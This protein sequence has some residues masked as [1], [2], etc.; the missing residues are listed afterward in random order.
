MSNPRRPSFVLGMWFVVLLPIDLTHAEQAGAAAKE[1]ALATPSFLG[2]KAAEAV[3]AAGTQGLSLELE[4]GDSA[5]TSDLE[6]SVYAQSPDSGAPRPSGPVLVKLYSKPTTIHASPVQA[7]R[8]VKQGARIP[9]FIGLA[10]DEANTV[11]VNLGL[12]LSS[13]VGLPADSY[14]KRSQIYAQMPAA[15]S[16]SD[17]GRVEVV[18][19]NPAG[20]LAVDPEQS[21]DLRA[22]GLASVQDRA[23]SGVDPE[24]GRL[25]LR[26]VDVL[27]LAGASALT[28][29]RRF[30]PE[31]RKPGLLGNRWRIHWEKSLS[32]SG[33]LAAIDDGGLLHFFHFDAARNVWTSVMGER[34]T[35]DRDRSVLQKG[36]GSEL[37]FDSAGRCTEVVEPDGTRFKISYDDNGRL[38]H[39]TGPF[40]T[41]IRFLVTAN[42]RLARV[43]CSNGMSVRYGFGTTPGWNVPRDL[44]FRFEYDRRG[45]PVRIEDP[46]RG[47][48]DIEY[49]EKQR[50]LRRSWLDSGDE[51]YS[52]DDAGGIRRFTDS[53]GRTSVVQIVRSRDRQTITTTDPW[54][55]QEYR[56]FDSNHRLIKKRD[57]TGL[58]SVYQYDASGRT[59]QI[60][61][62]D[63]TTALEYLKNTLLPTRIDSPAGTTA[64]EYDARLQLTRVLAGREVLRER[65][66]DAS[67][68]LASSKEGDGPETKY[69]HD[70]E[71]RLTAT[72]SASSGRTAF[73]YDRRGNLVECVDALGNKATWSY[74]PY[75]RLVAS[76]DPLGRE[77]K[78]TYG[79]RGELT[80]IV[81]AKGQRQFT[82]RRDGKL[83]CQKGPGDRMMDYVYDPRGRLIQRRSSAG[84][85]E[86][87]SYDPDGQLIESRSSTGAVWKYQY[88]HGGRLIE[89]V[90]PIGYRK[91]LTYDKRGYLST[92]TDGLGR[93][94][95][96]TRDAK[97]RVIAVV[98]PAGRR[99]ECRYDFEGRLIDAK[100]ALG[101]RARLKI[102]EFGR[103]DG[104]A[105]D[106]E[107]LVE[108]DRQGSRLVVRRPGSGEIS[109][110]V[111][112][113]GHPI[114]E[115]YSNGEK[116]AFAYD[117]LGRIVTATDAADHAWRA[118]YSPVGEL[119]QFQSPTGG[120][121]SYAYTNG[122][123]TEVKD[124]MGRIRRCDY[125]AWGR[126]I[127]STDPLGRSTTFTY[128]L[129][130]Q[131][132][133]LET[134]DG[135]RTTFERDL[136]GRIIA[137]TA[138][139][140]PPIRYQY[141]V[142]GNMTEASQ[143]EYRATHRYD[144]LDR[145][146]ETHYSPA[147]QTIRFRYDEGDRRTGLEIVGVGSWT[148]SY[149]D[150]DRVTAIADVAGTT[151]R[152][153]YDGAGR[154]VR[155][156][157]SNGLELRRTFDDRGRMLEIQLTNGNADRLIHR[158]YEHNAVGNLV[159]W[160]D[161]KIVRE[162]TYD[163]ENRLVRESSADGSREWKYDKVGNLLV[164]EA[165]YGNA[166]QLL[167]TRDSTYR[168]SPRG[169]A[170]RGKKGLGDPRPSIRC[171]RA[172][173]CRFR[174]WKA[175]G[176]VR[177]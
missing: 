152:F 101:R 153:H 85:T 50:V 118:A 128:D 28:V 76:V 82:Y 80:R 149:D 140:E 43:E 146:I 12:E 139:D 70:R 151:T 105:Q 100:D 122:L 40:Q 142:V 83:L 33:N 130:G 125:D 22:V 163:E 121:Y 34:L 54:G 21:G 75:D 99:Q 27:V 120:T 172:T 35:I 58:S 90:G 29:E 109:Y 31:T 161:D 103:L 135:K 162:Y 72:E 89:L 133:Q 61:D 98:D 73:S 84:F 112:P 158:K 177:L 175:G 97:G 4:I 165:E 25:F 166:D 114:R 5:P 88:D 3:R 67:G 42:G 46:F 78:F 145:V 9:D 11:A 79:P 91:T 143:G 48:V 160:T 106:S 6:H 62:D 63:G 159:R 113:G 173:N 87:Y 49:D 26:S 156:Q 154:V 18:L 56:E 169:A 1:Q 69:F 60:T 123:V 104:V 19:F 77:T 124:P 64:F 129:D 47:I 155:A 150:L 111:D 116:Y 127:R 92:V 23:T 15:G 94:T 20:R 53:S 119:V 30:L 102:D 32:K 148:Y 45:L 8:E 115:E 117:S 110:A 167:K 51:T 147:N 39:V 71:G 93:T 86:D 168:Y 10:I 138:T 44:T 2:M 141:D 68:L 7:D 176:G 137:M 65:K 126:R 52:Y 14:E 157:L 107:P 174:E 36:D 132:Q 16:I 95:K 74:D 24:T 38:A 171:R 81:D 108:F 170:R 144:L 41:W 55:R 131:L 164:N 57:F 134:A 59:I 17:N 96:Y 66:Y 37:T 13:R 136:L